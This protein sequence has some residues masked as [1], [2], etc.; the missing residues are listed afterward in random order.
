MVNGE[1]GE[2]V[3]PEVSDSVEA[4]ILTVCLETK[5][6]TREVGVPLLVHRRCEEPM[7]SISN[8]IAY[9]NLM[10]QAK[11]SKISPI[12]DILGPSQWID[13]EGRGQEKWCQREGEVLLDML[14]QLRQQEIAPDFYIVTPFVVVQD[15]MRE[16]L[17]SSGLL[18]GWVENPF[19][20]VYER[21]GT[22]HTVQGREAE[23]I[24]FILGA[25]NAEQRGA[26]GWAGGR[27]NLLNVAVTRAKEVV[28]VIGNRA[29]WKSAGVFQS[30]DKFLL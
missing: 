21:V 28:Y 14:R 27:P 16:M 2:R 13:V 15:R 20:W 4:T 29:L 19:T 7:F 17:R 6:G 5:S 25:P 30:L 9:E 3:G 23:A 11:T 24:F 10:V 26:R 18:D 22:V 1:G 8:A 12:R